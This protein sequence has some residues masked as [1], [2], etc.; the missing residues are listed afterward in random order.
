MIVLMVSSD[1]IVVLIVVG[2][3]VVVSL[4]S[5]GCWGGEKPV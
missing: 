4:G 3:V 5:Y 2:W 1:C